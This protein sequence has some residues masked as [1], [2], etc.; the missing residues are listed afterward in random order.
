MDGSLMVYARF[1]VVHCGGAVVTRA[2]MRLQQ[3]TDACLNFVIK[4]DGTDLN[5]TQVSRPSPPASSVAYFPPPCRL[6]AGG[7][8]PQP[9]HAT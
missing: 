2:L 4:E 7:G 5:F 8:R 1:F 6:W 3:V 9:C